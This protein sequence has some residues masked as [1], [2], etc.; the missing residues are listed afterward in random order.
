[1]EF[2]VLGPPELWSAG[3]Q[4]NIGPTRVRGLMAILLLTPRTIVP[5]EILIER[6]WDDRPPPKARESLSVYMAR[7]RAYLRQAVGDAVRVAGRASGYVLDVDPEAVDLHQFRRL[8]RHAQAL[9]A[10]G[11]HHHAAQLLREA[12]GL[13]RGQALA[14]IRGDWVARMRGSLEEERRAGLRARVECELELGRHADLVGELRGLLAQYPLDETLVGHQMI[15]LYGSGR[16]ADALS[17]YR[18]TRQRMVD[19]QG[20]DPGAALAELHQ[21]ILCRDPRLAARPAAR[22]PGLARLPETLPPQ[23]A[24]F[25]GRSEELAQL[26]SGLGQTPRVLVIEGTPGVGK[27]AFAVQAARMVADHYPDGMLYLNLES[28]HPGSASLDSAAALH[29]LLEMIGVPASQVPEAFGDRAALWHA[30]LSRRRAVVI[31]DDAA[32]Q[33]QVRPLVPAAGRCLILITARR[34]LPGLDGAR[35]LTLDA[36]SPEEAVTLFTRIA[37]PGTA[38]DEDEISTAVRL[39]GRLPLAI[40]LTAGRLARDY[41]RKLADLVGELS[42]TPAPL[43]GPGEANPEVM[44]AV[45]LSY[46]GL[47]PCHQRLFRQL[48]INPCTYVSPHGAAAMSGCTLEE[49]EKA[50]TALLDQHL[51]IRTAA[52]QYRFHDLIREFAVAR[53]DHEDRPVEQRMAVSRLLNYYLC[54]AD[55]ADRLLHPFRHRMK[56]SVTDPPAVCPALRSHDDASTWLDLEW[57]NVLLA[58]QH[59]GRHEWN[60]QCADLIH[61]LAG[62]VEIGGY[63][64]EAIAAHTL[65]LQACRDLGDRARVA[66]ASLELSGVS[67]QTG[68]QEAAI[69]LAEE[70][71][72]IYRLQADQR[73]LGGALDQIGLVNQRAG[74]SREALAYF[75]EAGTLYSEAGDPHGMASTLSHAGIACW[76]LGHYPDAMRHLRDALSLYRDGGDPRGEAKTLNNLGKIQLH[77]GC[78]REALDSFHSSLE[79]FS[80]IGG[81]QNQAILYH[82]IGNVYGYQGSHQNALAAYRRALAIYRGLGDLPDEANVLN[83]IGAIYQRA[84]SSDEALIYYQ[85]SRSIAEEIGNL[86]EQV[87]AL[88]GIADVQRASGRYSGALDDYYSALTLARDIGDPYQEAKILE[89][90]AETTLS[91][92]EPDAARIVFRQALDIFERLGVP[93]AE[94]AR[95]RLETTRPTIGRSS[96]STS[97]MHWASMTHVPAAACRLA[98][99]PGDAAAD[100]SHDGRPR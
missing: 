33:D 90:I 65:A 60:R 37:G 16:P 45:D 13:W 4:H 11:D 81:A 70:A 19:E 62:F 78:H 97:P 12:D 55:K 2:R 22:R 69:A 40:Q 57:R 1:M 59:A 53:A 24:E 83:D 79:I 75:R 46:R 95:I 96:S 67:L 34:G 51:V 68:R 29:R 36:L 80:T 43:D 47:D 66:Q 18:E 74:R 94:L 72:A 73:G 31:L 84:E 41:P 58:A 61:V 21:R 92:R 85:K 27:S 44:S 23:T 15:A 56:V 93:E 39:C 42:Q 63:W 3:Q 52:G 87:I 32:S 28:H 100:Q 26:A 48:G 5:A 50:L 20:T 76:H 30:Q 35:A 98:V 14:G 8:R 71:A 9:I 88:R 54:T 91:T 99:G 86:S 6:L 64:D 17:L 49:A 82:N 38:R 25:V 7:L 10:T 77:C 89:G